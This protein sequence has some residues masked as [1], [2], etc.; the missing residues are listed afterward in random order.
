MTFGGT[1]KRFGGAERS[2]SPLP[3]LTQ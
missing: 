3:S 1:G 2:P